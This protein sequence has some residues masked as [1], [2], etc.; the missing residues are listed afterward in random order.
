MSKFFL[1]LLILSISSLSYEQTLRET[2]F[3]EVSN[4]QIQNKA[5]G[6]KKSSTLETA[7]HIF[8]FVQ[9]DIK[10][11]SYSNTK[12]GA[13]RTLNERKG[14]CADQAH[15]L[16]ALLRADGIPTCY[17]HGTDHWWVVPCIDGKQYHCDPTNKKHDFGN[18]NHGNKHPKV[19]LFN[20]LNH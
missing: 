15:L 10:Y 16:V 11:E 8:S 9:V 3:C 2:T 20:E 6:L 14:N 12:K 18:P 17:A 13:V 5:R 4:S 1:L 7:K 19:E